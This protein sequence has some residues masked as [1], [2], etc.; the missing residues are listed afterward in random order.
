MQLSSFAYPANSSL[1]P[2][3]FTSAGGILCLW[4]SDGIAD[5][6]DTIQLLFI[7]N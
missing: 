6:T 7:E 1:N 3:L 2:V 5:I 4:T